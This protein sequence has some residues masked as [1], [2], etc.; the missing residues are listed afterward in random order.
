V[1][2]FTRATDAL[3]AFEQS[4]RSFDLV[5]TDWNMPGLSGIDVVR[6]MQ[7][8]DPNVRIVLTSGYLRAREIEQA[9][10]LGVHEVVLKP[11]T[12]EEFGPLVRRLLNSRNAG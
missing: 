3:A 8:I 11:N 9:R 6:E 7:R 4:P 12:L 2:G 10:E 1:T 5:I